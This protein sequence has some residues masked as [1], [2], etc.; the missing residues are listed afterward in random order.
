MA[1]VAV[2][3]VEAH[4]HEYSDEEYEHAK[5][6]ELP[7]L[8]AKVDCVDHKE[9][10]RKENI[11][12]YP[13]LLLFIDGE[14]WHGGGY[15]GSRTVTAMTDWL[16]QVEDAHKEEMADAPRNIESAHS[17]K[18]C[19]PICFILYDRAMFFDSSTMVS[20]D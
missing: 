10:C 5:K 7:V 18:C 15:R 6:V 17:G 8:V 9:L 11:R 19:F 13:T 20:F 1:D 12:A 3:R 2:K 16:R 4:E 14:R